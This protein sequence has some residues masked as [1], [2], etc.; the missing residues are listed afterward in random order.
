[1]FFI[2]QIFRSLYFWG[3]C[4]WVLRDPTF[5]AKKEEKKRKSPFVKGSRQ[6]HI[7]RRAKL[8][9][10]LSKMAW[11]F[12]LVRGKVQKSRLRIVITWFQSDSILGVNSDLI[13]NVRSQLEYLR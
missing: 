6:G 1:M 10:Y 4:I 9:G 2:R 3:Y 13:L 5:A 7:K 11:T 12:G 8:Q